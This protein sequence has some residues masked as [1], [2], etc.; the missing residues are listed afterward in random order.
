[1]SKCKNC[2][3]KFDPVKFL[4]KYCFK[5]ECVKVWIAKETEKQWKSKKKQM[6]QKTETLQDHVKKT[7]TIFNTYIRLRDANEKCISCQKIV[8]KKQNAGHF[9]NAN[10]HWNVRFDEENV[11]MQCE[12]CNMHLHGNLILYQDGL[13]KKIGVAN[14]VALENRAKNVTR[15]FTIPELIEI[16]NFYK[17]KIKNIKQ[18]SVVY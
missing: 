3:E 12:Y 16:Q 10:N 14:Y 2:K 8:L 17:E 1:M 13:I 15:K 6:I 5:P 11:N 4:Q 18:I 7:Q 9:W